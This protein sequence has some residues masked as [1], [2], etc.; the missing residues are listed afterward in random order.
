MLA[1]GLGLGV[2]AAIAQIDHN[3]QKL[4]NDQLPED[5]PAFFFVDI[6]GTAQLDSFREQ[7]MSTEGTERL[8]TAPM[9]RGVITELNGVPAKDATIDPAAAWVLRGDRGVD[10][11]G[12]PARRRRGD[13]W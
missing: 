12:D 13:R 9:L 8:E 2:L 11:F 6:Q 4:L 1:L 3:M 7:V 5:A 10:L